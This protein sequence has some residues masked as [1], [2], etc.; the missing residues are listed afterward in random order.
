MKR[1]LYLVLFVLGLSA[2]ACSF[3]EDNADVTKET[4]IPVEFTIDASKLCDEASQEH[5]DDCDS[6]ETRKAPAT[7]ELK[8]IEQ[9]LD[10]DIVEATG[11]EEL[12]DASGEFKEITITSID[13]EFDPNTLNFATPKIDVF[14]GPKPAGKTGDEDV[15]KLTTLPP[16]APETSDTGSAPVEPS[17]ENKASDLFKELKFSTI[18]AGQPKIRKDKDEIPPK[19]NADVTLTLNV[20]F[21]FNPAE[22]AGD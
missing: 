22:A 7:I 2:L 5:I 1:C 6:Q 21:V 15:F 9:D 12:R 3:L 14:V 8:P 20:Q 17:A 13:Y 10:I 19:G 4:E 11:K 16:V 18:P